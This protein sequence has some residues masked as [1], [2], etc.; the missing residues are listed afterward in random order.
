MS[1]DFENIATTLFIQVGERGEDK[2]RVLYYEPEGKIKDTLVLIPG[3][4]SLP[5]AW[6]VFLDE[7]K[8][9]HRIY[10]IETREKH[11]A[12]LSKKP[13]L[14]EKRFAK[15]IAD[16]IDYLMLEDYLLVASSMSGAFVLVALS[17]HL[18]KPRRTYLVGPVRK[19]E[20]PD[21][22]WPVAYMAIGPV[23]YL[24]L[25]PLVKLWLKYIYLD[26]TQK[27]QAKKYFGYFDSYNV[28]RARKSI[29]TMRK[30]RLTDEDLNKV[31]AKC[32]LIGAEKDKAHAADITIGVGK[33][34][35]DSEY[36][37]LE[38]NI[39]T[40]STP[41]VELIEELERKAKK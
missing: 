8:E 31:E 34:I 22:A 10:V 39:A 40:H 35:K 12:E 15:D 4:G 26:R 37:D 11:T 20:I 33:A 14:D 41:F 21:F 13:E 36:Y 18:I 9:N 1:S 19:V 38:T 24:I 2:I 7:M 28:P 27:E 5:S 30:F 16:A 23:W 25:K 29:L 32:I 3:F 17:M 6:D